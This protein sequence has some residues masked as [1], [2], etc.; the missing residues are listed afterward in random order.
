MVE[1]AQ[2]LLDLAGD[3]FAAMNKA[4]TLAALAWTAEILPEADRDQMLKESAEAA[5]ITGEGLKTFHEAIDMLIRR[6]RALGIR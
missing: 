4:L 1:L 6:K 5:G 2:P 3:D